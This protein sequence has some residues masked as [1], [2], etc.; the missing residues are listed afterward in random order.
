[1]P[2]YTDANSL[3]IGCSAFGVGIADSFRAR[4][5]THGGIAI[6]VIRAVGI[7]GT[8][9]K[10]DGT[11]ANASWSLNKSLG[12][13]AD[14]SAVR[15][16]D[17]VTKRIANASSIGHLHLSLNRFASFFNFRNGRHTTFNSRI[18][19]CSRWTDADHSPVRIGWFHFANG[20]G[21][22]RLKGAARIFTFAI[23][24]SLK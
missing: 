20:S 8:F 21:S 22:A 24:A 10:K 7:G 5:D 15:T 2:W 17:E 11:D 16:H 19:C 9:G 18:T 6:F 1:M 4:I 3:V 14:A 13:V 12:G 23:D